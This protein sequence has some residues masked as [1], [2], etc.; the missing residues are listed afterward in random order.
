MSPDCSVT[1]VPAAHNGFLILRLEEHVDPRIVISEKEPDR[2]R[3]FISYARADA[4]DFVEYL[5]VGL[6]LSGFDP[7]VDRQ[8][9]AKAEVWEERIGDLIGNSDT[10]IFIITPSA[11][12]SMRCDWEVKRAV[13]LGKR[14]VPVQ[15]MPVLEADVPVELKRLN[16]TIFSSGQP[17]S[18]PFSE[19]AESL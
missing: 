14:I 5:V 4:S 1:R 10:V 19:L 11:V 6:K 7:Y 8:D 9:I 15:W 17:F 13:A 16:Y 2:L 3:V 12:K 18:G